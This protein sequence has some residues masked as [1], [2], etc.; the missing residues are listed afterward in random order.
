MGCERGVPWVVALGQVGGGRLVTAQSTDVE[1]GDVHIG[2]AVQGFVRDHCPMIAAPVQ[3][4]VDGIAKG[5]HMN[6][7]LRTG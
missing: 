5:A 1:P 2:M 3:G 4:D 7:A 6:Y